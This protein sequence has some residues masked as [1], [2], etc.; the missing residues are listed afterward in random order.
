MMRK[1]VF[2]LALVAWS[3]RFGAE[4]TGDFWPGV[5]GLTAGREAPIK[6]TAT[7]SV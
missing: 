1:F 5:F 7:K 4:L 3:L 6:V 2:A